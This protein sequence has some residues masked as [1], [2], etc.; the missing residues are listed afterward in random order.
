[1]HFPPQHIGE[2]VWQADTPPPPPSPVRPT[3]ASKHIAAGPSRLVYEFPQDSTITYTLEEVL[4]ALPG[5][6]LRV[7]PNATPAGESV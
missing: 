3:R 2:E 7:S 6:K 4:Q 1:M 5:L